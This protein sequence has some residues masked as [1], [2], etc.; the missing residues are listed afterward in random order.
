MAVTAAPDP[1]SET[2]VPPAQTTEPAARGDTAVQAGPSEGGCIRWLAP[3]PRLRQPTLIAAFEGWNDAGDAATMAARHLAERWGCETVADID[4]ELFYDFTSTRPT[5]RLDDKRERHLKWP[6][7]AVMAAG[8][9]EASGDVAVLLGV[10]PQLRWRTFGKQVISIAE[11]LGVTRVVTLGALLAEV[12]H[13][14]PVQVYG[15]AEDQALRNEFRLAQSTY[16]GPT[17]IVGVL[18]AA[19]RDAGFPTV[20]LWS[21]VPSYMPGAPSPKAALALVRRTGTILGAS[22]ETAV[23]KRATE[24]YERQIAKIVASDQETAEFVA[25]I[26]QAWDARQERFARRTAD[27]RSSGEAVSPR[28]DWFDKTDGLEGDPATLVAEVEQFLRDSE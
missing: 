27:E 10:E 28:L 21:A 7:N 9:P 8:L 25:R 13:S 12:P 19:C 20:S 18:T 3:R 24:A 2:A 11:T 17:G 22:V 16:E 14:R 6:S 4:P 1:S 15:T 23:L 5:V 26:E